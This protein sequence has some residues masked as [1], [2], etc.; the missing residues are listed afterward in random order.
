MKG[1]RFTP[2]ALDE[3]QR[4]GLACV[5][6]GLDFTATGGHVPSVPAGTVNGT[7]VF[8]CTLHVA[9]PVLPSVPGAYPG[10]DRATVRA[11]AANVL[12]TG[13]ATYCSVAVDGRPAGRLVKLADRFAE[14]ADECEAAGDVRAAEVLDNV[15][16][17]LVALRGAVADG[18]GVPGALSAVGKA[19]SAARTVFDAEDEK[20]VAPVNTPEERDDLDELW[21]WLKAHLIEEFGHAQAARILAAMIDLVKATGGLPKEDVLRVGFE[22]LDTG[23]TEIVTEYLAARP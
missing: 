9:L 8:A 2:A 4:D 10:G 15:T 16:V 5:V 1:I 7:Q 13:T 23:R 11:A 3:Q 22:L 14:A 12:T 21:E 17:A 6:C 19:L 18:E 20:A